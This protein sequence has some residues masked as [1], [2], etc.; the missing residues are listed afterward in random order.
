MTELEAFRDHARKMATGCRCR[1]GWCC[2]CYD[3]PQVHPDGWMA[4]WRWNQHRR[5]CRPVTDAERALWAQLAAEVDTYLAR[6]SD[7]TA[8]EDQE[9]ELF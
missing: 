3:H 8:D 1:R 9:L 5:D 6:G 7:T 4:A 2:G